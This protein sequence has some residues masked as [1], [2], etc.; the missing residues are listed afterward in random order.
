M[1]KC[2]SFKNACGNWFLDLKQKNCDMLLQLYCMDG[3]SYSNIFFHI[4]FTWND[5]VIYFLQNDH[6]FFSSENIIIFSHQSE[7]IWVMCRNATMYAIHYGIT[8]YGD[9]ETGH[10]QSLADT[11]TT[12]IYL[13][14]RVLR[15]NII[16]F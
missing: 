2:C 1:K 3:H 5:K 4:T 15:P 12:R 9:M 7:A 6:S 11:R 10:Q 13:D 8:L 14:R 16:K